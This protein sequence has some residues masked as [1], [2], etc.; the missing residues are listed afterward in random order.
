MSTLTVHTEL[1]QRSDE[2]YAARA[3]LVTA[4]IVGGLVAVRSLGALECDC[5]DCDVV[6]GAA[7]VSKVKR[8]GEV[9]TPIKTPHSAR[10]AAAQMST[11]APVVEVADNDTSRGI[12]ALLATERITGWSEETAMTRDMWRG[13]EAEPFAREKYAE[14][15][16]P[17]TEVGFMVRTFPNGYRLGFSPDGL[18]GDDGLIEV[19]APRAKSHLLTILTGEVPA[20][21]LPQL[22]AGLLVSGR[23]WIDFVS[24]SGGLPLFT[25]RVLPD[26]KWHAAILAALKQF[27][28]NAGDLLSRYAAAAADLPSTDRLPNYDDIRV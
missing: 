4:S 17:V 19:K 1:V 10:N 18:V 24:F 13:A 9:G 8:A 20:Q 27:E 26:A 16:A 11:K 15:H 14:H 12:T 5:P 23:K 22:Q 28:S 2:W 3:G 25:K 7:C 6:P 21:H